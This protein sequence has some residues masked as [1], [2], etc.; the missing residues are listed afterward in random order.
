MAQH[1]T[2]TEMEFLLFAGLTVL[3]L[4]AVL[5]MA[6]GRE[7]RERW[8][9][10]RRVGCP[11]GDRLA[12]VALVVEACGGGEVYRDVAGC[13]LRPAGMRVDCGKEC[14]STS[15]APFGDSGPRAPYALI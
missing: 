14:R 2:N 3:T 13:S 15:V 5:L 7:R 9:V 8:I 10:R 12:T 11:A 1:V 4:L 6:L